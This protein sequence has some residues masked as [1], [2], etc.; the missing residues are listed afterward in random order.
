MKHRRLDLVK[1]L[2][3]YGADVND[4]DLDHENALHLA[5]SNSDYDMIDYLVNYTEV[6]PRAKNRDDMNPLCLLL[7]RSR[8]DQDLVLSCFHAMLEHTYDKNF[9]F[10]ETYEVRDIFQCAFLACV[11]SHTEVVKFLIYNAYSSCWWKYPFAPKLLEHCDSE[12]AEF[13]IYILVF[14]HEDIRR[15]DQFAFSRFYEINSFM[16]VRSTIHA[17]SVLLD[18]DDAVELVTKMLTHLKNLSFHVLVKEFEDEFGTLLHQKY[19]FEEIPDNDFEKA[20]RI[21]QYLMEE[22]FKLNLI[23]RSFLHSI[24]IVSRSAMI[25][26]G[27]SMRIVQLLLRY[28]PAFFT[29]PDNLKQIKEFM[30][31]NPPVRQIVERLAREFSD[32]RTTAY[33]DIDCV[34]SL[35]HSCRNR[36]RQQLRYDERVL[37]NNSKMLTL[38]LP[39]VLINYIAFKE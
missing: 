20:D 8:N 34:F 32:P 2:L 13:C 4:F 23:L 19:S 17:I 5:A 31:L 25:N 37:C 30:K 22:G 28:T 24:A 33:L 38:G 6:D 18:E 14:V 26:V 39:Q 12:Y 10:P 3:Q 36:I 1:L 9:Q 29:V 15:Y 35:M 7:V 11:Y 27:S 16:S 21:L